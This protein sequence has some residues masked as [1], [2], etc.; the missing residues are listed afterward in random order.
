[1]GGEAYSRKTKKIMDFFAYIRDTMSRM[2][3]YLAWG[4]Y[5]RIHIRP[6]EIQHI[7]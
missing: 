3:L 1:M 5:S 7:F 2:V 4:V 6:H